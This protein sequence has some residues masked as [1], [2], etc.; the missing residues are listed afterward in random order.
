MK[1]I[2]LCV[3]IPVCMSLMMQAKA[4]DTLPETTPA[5]K[6]ALSDLFELALQTNPSLSRA[7]AEQAAA[8]SSL[9]DARG[10]LKPEVRFNSELS[11]AWMKMD[12]F[13]RTANQ[14]IATYPL[15]EPQLNDLNKSAD[16]T[17]QSKQWRS[18]AE[19]QKVLFKV[20]ELYFTYWQQREDFLFLKKEQ[21]SIESIIKQVRQRFQVGYQ[22]LN[23]IVEIQSRLDF[24]HAELLK[25]EQDFRQTEA[26][27]T[28]VLGD[29]STFSYD[30]L[31]FPLK[32]APQLAR[33]EREVNVAKAENAQ[34]AWSKLVINNPLLLALEQQVQAAQKQVEYVK[35]KDSVQVEAFGALVYNDSDKNFYDD[36]QGARGGLRLNVPLYLGGRTEA[37]VSKQRSQVKELLAVKRETSLSLEAQARNAWLA[38]QTGTTRLKA[39]KAA[40]ESSR[41]AVKASEQALK[42]GRRNVLDLLDAQRHLHKIERDLPILKADIWKSYYLFYWTIGNLNEKT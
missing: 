40:L 16:S 37:A 26:K 41:Q 42:T 34:Q 6:L 24:N 12:E 9:Q 22:D 7:D 39:L 1:R 2:L 4:S 27:L 19:K 15:Y 10:L 32:Q 11:Y 3:F 13:P 30:A 20:A 21:R 8:Y 29:A 33:L 36:M 35:N 14:L 23:D 38:L 31:S 17:Y 5:G 28:A 18:E 25:A